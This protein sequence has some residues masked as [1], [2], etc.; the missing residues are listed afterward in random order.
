MDL[1]IVKLNT[2]EGRNGADV[3]DAALRTEGFIHSKISLQVR[4]REV[5]HPNVMWRATE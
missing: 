5:Q 2:D 1:I 4:A 3:R